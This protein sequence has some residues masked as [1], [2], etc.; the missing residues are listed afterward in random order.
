MGDPNSRWYRN[1]SAKILPKLVPLL[2]KSRRKKTGWQRFFFFFFKL[3]LEKGGKCDRQQTTGK[4]TDEI[5]M[6]NMAEDYLR[7]FTEKKI[8]TGRG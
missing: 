5:A 8:V 2:N 7:L 1:Y 4:E 6:K 3:A